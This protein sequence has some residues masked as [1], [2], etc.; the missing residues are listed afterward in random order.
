M[1]VT[2]QHWGTAETLAVAG[3]TAGLSHAEAVLA[4]KQLQHHQTTQIF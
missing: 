4:T 3:P 2:V 1:A